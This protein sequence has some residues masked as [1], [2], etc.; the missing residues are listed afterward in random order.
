MKEPTILLLMG[1]LAVS[2]SMKTLYVRP[3]ETLSDDCPT[4]RPCETLDEYRDN[5]ET[6]FDANEIQI[7]FLP[8]SYHSSIEEGLKIFD[9]KALLIQGTQEKIIFNR[10]EMFFLTL[11]LLQLVV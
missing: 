2:F 6:Y 3:T 11:K 4:N 5:S 10:V 8:G 1:L 7:I 9:K